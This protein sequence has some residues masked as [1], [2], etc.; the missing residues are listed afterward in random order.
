MCGGVSSVWQP[1]K[2]SNLL[3]TGSKPAPLS[4]RAIGC[5]CGVI[6]LTPQSQNKERRPNGDVPIL[7]VPPYT[8]PRGTAWSGKRES[9]SRSQLGRLMYYHYTIPARCRKAMRQGHR[10]FRCA[11]S[12]RRDAN[13]GRRDRPIFI[14]ATPARRGKRKK[15]RCFDF[16]ERRGMV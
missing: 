10:L 15:T 8:P 9:N 12:L 3:K 1:M 14:I 7:K 11:K 5:V 13:D 4:N 6:R 2:E 16:L